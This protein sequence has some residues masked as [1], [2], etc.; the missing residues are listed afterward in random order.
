[1]ALA[2]SAAWFSGL[3]WL[4]P[5]APCFLAEFVSLAVMLWYD[6]FVAL[7]CL[8]AGPTWH[9][10]SCRFNVVGINDPFIDAK[11]RARLAAV[12]LGARPVM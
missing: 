9:A 8:N 12:A 10:P 6:V 1:M 11:V 7:C 3:R 2:A 4:T 5:G